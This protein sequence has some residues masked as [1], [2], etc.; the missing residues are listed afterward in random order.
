MKRFLF[1]LLAAVPLFAD[2]VANDA[3][4]LTTVI[5]VRHAETPLPKT[6]NDPELTEAGQAR[7]RELVRILGTTGIDTIYVTPYLRTRH[8]AA[9]LAKALNLES[10]EIKTGETYPKDVVE[11]IRKAPAGA[12]VLVVGHSNST[13]H[14]LRE[15]GFADAPFIPETEFDN[16]YIV[17]M[18]EGAAPRLLKLRY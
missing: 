3:A 1:A 18:A 9:P 2:A 5:L 7:A 14:V 15:L 17:T 10:L 4:K 8:T 16:L 12:T 11:R 6:T 13:Q